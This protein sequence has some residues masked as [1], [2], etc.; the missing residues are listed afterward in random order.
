MHIRRKAPVPRQGQNA[1]ASGS[2]A[3]G[4]GEVE[5]QSQIEY[6]NEIQAETSS[7]IRDLDMKWQDMR[8]TMSEFQRNIAQ[9][10]QLMSVLAQNVFPPPPLPGVYR[11]LHLSLLFFN[12]PV[13]I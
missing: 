6:L 5:L 10:D 11:Y 3:S 8:A 13:S 12:V 2:S 4:P 1:D 7:Q 9:Q